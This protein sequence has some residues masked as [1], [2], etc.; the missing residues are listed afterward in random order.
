MAKG[1]GAKTEFEL[2]LAGAPADIAAL[3]ASPITARQAR[4]RA[5]TAR[6]V[7]T[8]FDTAGGALAAAGISLRLRETAGGR[9]QTLKRE[10]GGGAVRR[11]EEEIAL[12]AGA[13]F[14]QPVADEKAAR[15]IA[16]AGRLV[17]VA[18]I[19]SDR[20]TLALE[21]GRTR[22]EAAF[23]LGRL[24]AWEEGALACA[25][26]LAEAEFELAGGDPR[27]L[28]DL[29]AAILKESGGRLRLGALSKAGQ[30]RRLAAA[31]IPPEPAVKLKEKDDAGDAL[32]AT[33]RGVAARIA[34]LIPAISDLR[35]A[36]GVHQMRIALRRLRAIEQSCRKGL[37]IKALKGLARRAGDF[38]GTLGPARDWDVFLAETLPP[39]ERSAGEEA[40]LAALKAR[41]EALRAAA[42]DEAARLVL[43]PAFNRFALDLVRAGH[44]EEWRSEAGKSLRQPARDF[45]AAALDAR[46]AEAREAARKIDSPDPAARHPLRIAL[47]KLRYNAQ[48]FR[49]LFPG[50]AR[51]DYM[52][53][54]A[55]LQDDLGAVNDAVIAQRLANEA[56]IGQGRKA[57]RASGFV[58][59][60]HAAAGAARA[61]AV[62]EDWRAFAA[63]APFWRPEE[64]VRNLEK[65]S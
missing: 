2:K 22:I 43:S 14:P 37:K 31:D 29:V 33:L 41:A 10:K 20:T 4:G 38:A 53:R 6:L 60:F 65:S 63:T 44:L 7:S 18:R 56:A 17:P 50:A 9:L 11:R 25:G 5:K 8:Y 15:I 62:G 57:A 58:A 45:A 19:V 55:R 16:R 23:D 52:A 30:A 1:G 40:G 28:F 13:E 32:A 64:E 27:D 59:G 12:G 3:A 47:K 54:L 26:P 42:W 49:T 51:K 24:E 34:E 48:I 35:L 61:K 46:L 36:E 21:K 39:L